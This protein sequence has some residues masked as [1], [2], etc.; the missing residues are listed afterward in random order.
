[1]G[2]MLGF[3]IYKTG[4]K[5]KMPKVSDLFKMYTCVHVPTTASVFLNLFL[6]FMVSKMYTCVKVLFITSVW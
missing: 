3:V 6:A 1:M 2:M 5:I 4:G